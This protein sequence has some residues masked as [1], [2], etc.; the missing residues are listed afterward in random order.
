MNWFYFNAFTLPLALRT[1]AVLAYLCL[2]I[3]QL[4]IELMFVLFW[5]KSPQYLN[6]AKQK[7]LTIIITWFLM[8]IV[9]ISNIKL[10]LN[11][12]Y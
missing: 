10:I 6:R 2:H 12:F 4:T 5:L 11:Y 3:L 1:V 9:L 8:I 7:Q